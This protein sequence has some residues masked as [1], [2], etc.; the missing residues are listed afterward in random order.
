MKPK[1]ELARGNSDEI[2]ILKDVSLKVILFHFIVKRTGQRTDK[3]HIAEWQKSIK[4][5]SKQPN[6][7]TNA[8]ALDAY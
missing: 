3:P 8:T 1:T 2:R 7:L 5:A 6:S 4:Q